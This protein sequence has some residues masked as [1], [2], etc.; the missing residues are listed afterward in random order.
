MA[1]FLTQII[2]AGDEVTEQRYSL[3]MQFEM[4]LLNEERKLMDASE[5]CELNVPATHHFSL[6][7]ALNDIMTNSEDD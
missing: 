1:S 6:E 7:R 2:S 5:C 4:I 3:N